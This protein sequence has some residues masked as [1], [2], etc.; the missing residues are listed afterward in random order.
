MTFMRAHI[1]DSRIRDLVRSAAKDADFRLQQAASTLLKTDNDTRGTIA[2][3]AQEIDEA[4][5]IGE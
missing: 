1:W 5:E 4:A 3:M 2:A